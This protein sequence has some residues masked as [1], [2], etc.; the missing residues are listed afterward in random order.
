VDPLTKS[1][2]II[3]E[4]VFVYSTPSQ[5][6]PTLR[7]TLE[8]DGGTVYLIISRLASQKEIVGNR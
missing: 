5:I 6:P 2:C 7:K 8:K 4:D 3:V 1:Y